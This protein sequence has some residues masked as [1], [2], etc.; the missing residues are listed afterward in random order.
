MRMRYGSFGDV[1]AISDIVSSSDGGGSTGTTVSHA[2]AE[3]FYFVLMRDGNP[4]AMALGAEG[5]GTL[6]DTGAPPEPGTQP[7]EI[8]SIPIALSRDHDGDGIDDVYELQRPEIF[9]PFDAA[10][11]EQ[12]SDG[13]GATNLEEYLAGTDPEV[14]DE[15][16]EEP[17]II[18]PTDKHQRYAGLLVDRLRGEFHVADINGDGILDFHHLSDVRLG[19]ADGTLQP[20]IQSQLPYP[21]A[22]AWVTGYFDGD[23][24]L[25]IALSDASSAPTL[26]IMARTTTGHLVAREPMLDLGENAGSLAAWDVNGD[27]LTDLAAGSRAHPR[28]RFFMQTD[29]EQFQLTDTIET[30]G[31][32]K[33]LALGD[34]NG[35]GLTDLIV[36]LNRGALEV[37]H[38]DAA[39]SFVETGIESTSGSDADVLASK[40]VNNDGRDDILQI[41]GLRNRLTVL[42]S[43]ADGFA[44]PAHYDTGLLPSDFKI[45]DINADG[46]ADVLVSHQVSYFH[47]LFLGEGSGG[48]LPMREVATSKSNHCELVDWDDDGTLDI[49]SPVTEDEALVVFGK[50]DGTFRTRDQLAL[51]RYP[52][53]A[54]IANID[55]DPFLE[56]LLLNRN[57]L[58]IWELGFDGNPRQRTHSIDVPS[59]VSSL[60]HA[61]F[62]GDGHLDIAILSTQSRFSFSSRD[63]ITFFQGDGQGGFTNAGEAGQNSG[64]VTIIVANMDAD[65][66]PDLLALTEDDPRTI[67]FETQVVPL[68]NQGGFVFT[69]GEPWTPGHY[70]SHASVRDLDDDGIDEL[71]FRTKPDRELAT[72]AYERLPA[73]DWIERDLGALQSLVNEGLWIEASDGLTFISRSWREGKTFVS[74]HGIVNGTF[75]E[76]EPITE[77]TGDHTLRAYADVDGDTLPD[78]LFSGDEILQLY[79]AHPDGSRPTEPEVVHAPPGG[80]VIAV[81]IDR[82]GDID[83]VSWQPVTEAVSFIL[84]R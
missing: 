40:D 36:S 53:D 62:N 59:V 14:F 55:A 48:L 20:L 77:V 9:D 51:T 76:Q 5:T 37:F 31:W 70:T 60:E 1:F 84:Q 12:D 67:E 73:G 18:R 34:C 33:K 35:D 66:L 26:T 30:S 16:P 46:H 23:D 6:I 8:L 17:E 39:G 49:V 44:A 4:V 83:L 72:V 63:T 42:L 25:D 47:G 24:D 57:S 69:P 21:H 81:D 7:Y 54:A 64:F 78:L 56:L 15:E 71:F 3:N 75:T 2:S 27:G 80:E 10:D 52:M 43:T 13:D 50:G 79:L 22:G 38:S 32:P 11:A 29:R 28:A 74:R 61:D 41:N 68:F 58:D 45:A 82:D 19:N 65:G